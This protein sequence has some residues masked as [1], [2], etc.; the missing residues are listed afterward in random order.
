MTTGTRCICDAGPTDE[1][2]DVAESGDSVTSPAGSG[3]AA[4]S[5]RLKG[6]VLDAFAS[7]EATAE[8]F[9]NPRQE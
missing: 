3:D 9:Q 4:Q 1:G 7:F 6:R 2:N 8:D 5:A